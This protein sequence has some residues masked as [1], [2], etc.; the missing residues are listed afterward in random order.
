MNQ[1]HK[2]NAILGQETS[3]KEKRQKVSRLAS[4]LWTDFR[5]QEGSQLV[6]RLGNGS[7]RNN[8]EALQTWVRNNLPKHSGQEDELARYASLSDALLGVLSDLQ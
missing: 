3:E 1:R 4:A 5:F 2:L 8:R 6:Y 7:E